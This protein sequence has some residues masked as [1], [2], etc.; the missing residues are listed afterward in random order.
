M[1]LEMDEKLYALMNTLEDIDS[2][3]YKSDDTETMR[4]YIHT[5]ERALRNAKYGLELM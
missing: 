5:L 3:I 1:P 2:E 4:E